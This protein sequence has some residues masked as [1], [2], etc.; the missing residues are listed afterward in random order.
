MATTDNLI[1]EAADN[2][3]VSLFSDRAVRA[4]PYP[5]YRPLRETAPVHHSA[6]LPL[7]VATRYDNCGTVLRDPRFGKSDEVRRIFRTI[8]VAV[9]GTILA[10]RLD[11][12]LADR[13]VGVDLPAGVTGDSIAGSLRAIAALPEPLHSA[14]AGA[15][16][17]SI[18]TVF[19]VAAVVMVGGF[20]I[21]IRM[22]E[23]PL[24]DLAAMTAQAPI[25]EPA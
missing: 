19:A 22:R 25:A 4:D 21:S 3:L 6:V 17:A 15:L 8:G 7:W 2:V 14:A 5:A 1:T 13:L 12:E 10:S 9:F 16:S 11:T 20:V 24:R 23:L 18:T